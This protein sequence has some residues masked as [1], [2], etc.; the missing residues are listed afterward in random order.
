MLTPHE[1]FILAQDAA[2]TIPSMFRSSMSA[3]IIETN[4]EQAIQR[5]DAMTG[6]LR[7]IEKLIREYADSR[8]KKE[9]DEDDDPW[10]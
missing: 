7:R 9:E 5:V 6:K 8:P 4:P 1:I 2:E 3:H 10:M